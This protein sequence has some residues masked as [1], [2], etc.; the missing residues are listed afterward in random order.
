MN[1]DPRNRCGR[2]LAG[3]CGIVDEM[4]DVT[5]RMLALLATLQ[6]GRGFTGA[7]LVDRLA[8]SPRTLRRDIDRL[9]GYG[10]PVT[11]RPGPGGHYRLA[12]G[13]ALPPLVLD[14]DE[15]IAALL[16]LALLSAQT[17]TG[18]DGV[19]VAATRAYGKLDQVLPARL[20]GRLAGLR[21]SLQTGE[22]PVPAVGPALLASLADAIVGRQIVTFDY[23]GGSR[24]ERRVE[25]YRQ[26]HH[27]LRWYL[28]GWDLPAR[29]WRIFRLDRMSDL[30]LTG[31]RFQPRELPEESAVELVRHAIA[32]RRRRISI[33]VSAP[34]GAVSDALRYQDARLHETGQGRTRVDLTVDS[35]P[36]LVLQLAMLDADFILDGDPELIADCRAFG[37]RLRGET[38]APDRPA[39]PTADPPG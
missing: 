19:D 37:R 33:T 25:P 7:E 4:A 5:E 9:R 26:V 2:I 20:R 14:D 29:D 13:A 23:S 3:S 30:L 38:I 17:S 28:L 6:S 8:V 1:T 31:H 35:W 10:Y 18:A 24:R 36:W 11:T 34:V 21:A 27:L 12:S 22:Q 15:A 32:G 39:V 16:G